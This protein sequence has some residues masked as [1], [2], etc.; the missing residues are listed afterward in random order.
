M[1]KPIEVGC[2]AVIYKAQ[3]CCGWRSAYFGIPFVVGRI[4][5]MPNMTHHCP[6]CFT[7]VGNP[8]FAWEDATDFCTTA[9]LVHC[10]RIEPAAEETAS[11]TE[12]KVEA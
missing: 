3:D 7:D 8:V 5:P 10:K 4:D 11:E 12:K 6:G 9:M 1:S 2:W